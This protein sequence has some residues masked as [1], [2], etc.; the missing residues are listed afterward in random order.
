MTCCP[1][2]TELYA[3]SNRLLTEI[4]EENISTRLEI[5]VSEKGFSSAKEIIDNDPLVLV[6]R[7]IVSHQCEEE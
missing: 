6:R 4:G 3:E 2:M 5:L 1:V 7:K